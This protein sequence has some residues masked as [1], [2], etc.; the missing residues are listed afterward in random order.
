MTRDQCPIPTRRFPD[1]GGPL[2]PLVD[3]QIILVLAPHICPRPQGRHN[4]VQAGVTYAE[5]FDV[6]RWI[7]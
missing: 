6:L 3:P 4:A 2:R 7:Q 5:T 1:S